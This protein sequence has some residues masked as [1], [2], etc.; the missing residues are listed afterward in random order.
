MLAASAPAAEREFPVEKMTPMPQP[1]IALNHLGFVPDARKLAL[2]RTGEAP[3]PAEFSL[4]QLGDPEKPFQITR[5]LRS[6]AS[7]LGECLVADFSDLTREG[8]YQITINGERSVPFFIRPDVWR[9]VLPK[10]VSYFH[11]QRCGV[12]VPN[13]HPACH[14]DDARRRDNGERVDVTGGWHDAGDL[15]K[16]MSATMMNGFGLMHLARRLG[17]KWDKGGAGLAPLLEEMRWGNRYF[18]KMQ[19]GDGLVWAD[20]AGG[21]NGDGVD[22]HWTD[23]Q[24]GTADD[25]HINTGKSGQVQ[26]MFVA[27]QAM[28]AQ[29]FRPV[30]AAYSAQ[31]LAA[32]QRCWK[33]SK[34][35]S[36]AGQLA[37]WVRAAL[38]L[39]RATGDAGLSTEAGNLAARLI[40]LQQTTFPDGQKSVRGY[41][42]TAA[43]SNEAYKSGTQSA[44]PPTVLLELAETL[45]R[46][47]SASRWLDA[48][49]LHLEDYALPLAARSAYGIL[50][51]G[52]YR[53][54]ISSDRYRELGGDLSYRFFMP[55]RVKSSANPRRQTAKW[56][57]L[58]SHLESYAVLGALAAKLFARREYSDLAYRQLE[59][60]MGA[61]PFGSCLMTGEGMRNV[62]P[63]S[64]FSGLIPGGI[65][66]G[67]AGNLKDEAVLDT[68]Y[69]YDWRTCEY[70]S[71][72][73]AH[74]VWAVSLL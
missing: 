37:W 44:L 69:G 53:G 6:G 55:V 35:G 73:N 56:Y 45:P 57:G 17:E 48:V 5:P 4:R 15:R 21:V 14:L 61:N 9:R 11:T 22:D 46:H 28:V 43:D 29:Q 12:E 7:E 49:R 16:W 13:V 50:P 32:A 25:R 30:D 19:D 72:H 66:N 60:V 47:P 40:E 58:T 63:H 27:L 68:T 62:Y 39:H 38:E 33:A 64:R 59:W 34:R 10:A 52:I 51:Y 20:T 1:A 8:L 42:R 23:N 70:W 2:Y 36:D 65:V 31:C 18:L 74:F 26:A 24:P 3:R 54:T 67:I 41:W 71:P